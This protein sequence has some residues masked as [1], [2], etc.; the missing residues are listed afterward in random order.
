LQ[1]ITHEF[2]HNIDYHT[3]PGWGLE[4]D[5]HREN[6]AINRVNLLRGNHIPKQE[7]LRTGFFHRLF[8]IDD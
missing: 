8:G 3:K 7:T 5:N 4:T 1:V 2:G 6:S